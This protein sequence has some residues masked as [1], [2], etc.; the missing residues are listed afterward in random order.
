M[1]WYTTHFLILLLVG[2]NAIST[3]E[4]SMYSVD[5]PVNANPVTTPAN[6]LNVGRPR[7]EKGT[8]ITLPR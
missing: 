4:H 5:P 8:E 2:V 6:L 3:A 1:Q 7:V